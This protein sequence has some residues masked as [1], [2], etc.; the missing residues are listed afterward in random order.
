MKKSIF[1]NQKKIRYVQA[2]SRT[3]EYVH[4]IETSSIT[5]EGSPQLKAMLALRRGQNNYVLSLFSDQ[6]FRLYGPRGHA[7]VNGQMKDIKW[8]Y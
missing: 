3:Y 2:Q 6:S 1:K 8:G 5:L 7:Y 4:K